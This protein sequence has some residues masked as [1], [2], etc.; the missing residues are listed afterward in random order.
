MAAVVLAQAVQAT[1][2]EVLSV[3]VARL[4]PREPWLPPSQLIDLS[5]VERAELTQSLMSHAAAEAAGKHI[6]YSVRDVEVSICQATCQGQAD[7]M[8]L[9]PSDCHQ[10]CS[11]A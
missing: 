11:V 3:H 4:K 10:G 8:R 6:S 1:Q 7:R 5:K 2:P 9:P